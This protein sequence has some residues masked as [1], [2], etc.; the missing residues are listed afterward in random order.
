MAHQELSAREPR[1]V[2][3]PL[4]RTDSI[5]LSPYFIGVLQLTLEY[6]LCSIQAWPVY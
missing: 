2:E 4:L 1:L 6:Y 5:Y 3:Y